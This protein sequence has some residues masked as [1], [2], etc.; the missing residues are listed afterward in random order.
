[1][2]SRDAARY[3]GV[4]VLTLHRLTYDGLLAFTQ[5]R[6]GRQ[7]SRKLYRRDDLDAF[8]AAH[9]GRRETKEAARRS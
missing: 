7:G 9:H 8:I 1:M 6:P 5:F 4:S 2:T 3:L